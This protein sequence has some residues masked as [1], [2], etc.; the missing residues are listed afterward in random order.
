LA[1]RAGA[2]RWV[3][4]M[5]LYTVAIWGA[6]V[7]MI[8]IMTAHFEAVHLA[9]IRTVVA[10][11]FIA[12]VGWFVGFRPR[13]LA[14][15]DFF[16]LCAAAFL[17]VY[18][19]QILLTQGLAWSTATNGGLALSL[20]PLLSVLL[21]AALFGER[22]GPAGVAGV[23]MGLLGAAVVILNRSGA[24]LRLHGAGDVL[25]LG[26]MLA[27]VGAGAVMRS[28]SQRL[29]SVAIAWHMHW[30]GGVMLVVHAALLP[31]FWTRDAWAA[32]VMPW[33]LIAVSGLFSTALGG[34][35]WSFGI[36]RLGL[37]RT[38]VFL[39]LLPVSTLLTAVIF[40]GER[41][42]PAHAVGFL[43][44]LCGTW[45]AVNGRRTAPAAPAASLNSQ[46]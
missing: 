34:L 11:C 36:K 24:E 27:Y 38:A 22:L 17:M 5:L 6:N 35:G 31:S 45:L 26:S 9:A 39:N 2:D 16:G 42:R 25:L 46:G 30:I 28:L 21:G 3:V 13:R 32:D 23:A 43:L 12:M 15:R 14:P 44:V 37:G 8:K 33:V 1:E 20:N 18:A 40:L 19:H 10:F 29:G 41:A 7:V 4:P